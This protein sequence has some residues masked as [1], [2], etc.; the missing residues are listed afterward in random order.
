[1]EST[2]GPLRSRWE[3]TGLLTTQTPLHIGC[4]SWTTRPGLIAQNSDGAPKLVEVAA[5][6]TD[7]EHRAYLPGT[8]LK[9]NL[10]TWANQV[11][12]ADNL[13]EVFGYA[14]QDG[15]GQDTGR[16]GL[17]EFWDAP[18]VPKQQLGHLPPDWN[19]ER[20]TGV[21]ASVAIA[22]RTRTASEQKLF[23]VEFVPPGVTFAT[24]IAGML[25]EA[26]ASALLTVLESSV[27]GLRL[28]AR[29]GDGWGQVRW[30][31]ES[32]KRLDGSSLRAWLQNPRG[33]GYSYL[34]TLPQGEVDKRRDE[35]ASSAKEL[36][37]PSAPQLIV[38]VTLSF[39]G[40]FLV[41][42]PRQAATETARA[43][44]AGSRAIT[45]DHT[46][47]LDAAG[48]PYLPAASL[49]GALRAHAERILRTLGGDA[50]ACQ[51]DQ[52]HGACPAVSS[53]GIEVADS[54]G[55]RPSAVE[56]LCPAC[57]L[58]GAPGW[59]S[60]LEVTDFRST[61][62]VQVE[63]QEFLAIDRFTGGGADKLKFNARR[64]MRPVLA[65]RLSLDISALDRCGAGA[66]ALG[67][68]GLLLRDLT[69]GDIHFGFGTSK[70]Y[71]AC[72]AAARVSL[73]DWP[74]DV[75][76]LAAKAEV[77]FAVGK[78]FECRPGTA[79]TAALGVMVRELEVLLSQAPARR[80]S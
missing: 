10:R 7:H 21:A 50:G 32:L 39:T 34:P 58:F 30:R 78:T 76:R 4:G 79:G 61:N 51:R 11:G 8:A 60:P 59:R 49:R 62:D 26:E 31:L 53:M 72:T 67:L 68:L 55:Q 74:D 18:A 45:P 29:T 1:M 17:A 40:G 37:R 54:N 16:G 80:S 56:A 3:I 27:A 47:R 64:A 66:W 36:V 44:E 46:P 19:L 33:I 2:S 63:T 28:G 43:A 70:G 15:A 13:R 75:P 42:D 69:E 24:S 22:R 38:D 6:A 65:G 20:L 73:V 23:Y 14:E 41:N 77:A 25:T 35:A 9:G 57:K 71:G 48:R 52:T 5:V 12:L